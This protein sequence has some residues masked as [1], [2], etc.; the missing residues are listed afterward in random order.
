[1][2]YDSDSSIKRYAERK[3]EILGAKQWNNQQLLK[4]IKFAEEYTCPIPLYRPPTCPTEDCPFIQSHP[5]ILAMLS[6]DDKCN[7][8][9]KEIK[10]EI[11]NTERDIAIFQECLYVGPQMHNLKE[12]WK[13]IYPVLDN[14][15]VLNQINLRTILLKLDQ[16]AC[17]YNHERFIRYLERMK[18]YEQFESLQAR[19]NQIKLELQTLE[20]LDVEEKKK[21]LQKAKDLIE[22]TNQELINLGTERNEIDREKEVLLK[23]LEILEHR[24]NYQ[25]EKTQLETILMTNRRRLQDLAD[26]KDQVVAN[27]QQIKLLEDRETVLSMKHMEKSKRFAA[28]QSTLQDIK[29]TKES[30][31]EYLQERDYLKYI[32]DAVGSKEGIPLLMV[33]SFLDQSR[34][35]INNL[36]SDIFEDDLEII[37]FDVSETSNEF[38]IPYRI[39]GEEVRDIELASQGQMSV[40]S[41]AL[42]FAFCQKSMFDYNIMLLDEIDN[43]IYKADREKF[44]AIL[45]KQMMAMNCDQVFLITHNDIFQQS[46]LPVNII[47]TTPEIIDPYPNQSIM[48]I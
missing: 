18:K 34:E 29:S 47:M 43:S 1:M 13:K 26:K 39:N 3:L 41:I 11:A 2:C 5:T 23:S 35:I 38:R 46:G 24:T 22:K 7:T 33:K 21:E 10:D 8:R 14:L 4:N 40:I 44:I 19:Y 36:I 31:E 17:W 20:D 25:N 32:L 16:R 42:S 28:V 15:G 27:M 37:D 45:S 12:M 30:Y 9:I 6:N 48:Q